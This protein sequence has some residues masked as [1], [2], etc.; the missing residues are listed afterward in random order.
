MILFK[1]LV[2]TDLI[3]VIALPGMFFTGEGT[4]KSVLVGFVVAG[5]IISVVSHIR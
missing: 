3:L 5:L 4:L 1:K 2:R